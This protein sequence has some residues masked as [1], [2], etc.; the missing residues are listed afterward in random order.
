MNLLKVTLEG[1]PMFKRFLLTLLLTCLAL[2]AGAQNNSRPIFDDSPRG[3]LTNQDVNSGA[4]PLPVA[5]AKT[6]TVPV[7]WAAK[8]TVALDGTSNTLLAANTSRVGFMVYNPTANAAIYID[9]GGGTAVSEQGIKVAPGTWFSMTGGVTP[10][11]L[12]TVLGTNAQ[13]IYVW[14]GS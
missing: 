9:I 4:H 10:V 8:A 1:N 13:S 14:Q 6:G 7:T 3:G 12:I 11:N 2:P 5:I